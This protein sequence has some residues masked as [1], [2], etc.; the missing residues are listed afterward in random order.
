MKRKVVNIFTLLLGISMGGFFLKKVMNGKV[1]SWK[2]S[3]DKYY[4]LFLMMNQWVKLHQEG[5]KI[6][7]F[8]EKKGYHN[9]A[10]YGMSY[11]GETLMHELKNSRVKVQYGIDK[12]AGKLP[13][14]IKVVYPN[15]NLEEVDV[16]VVTPIAYYDEIKSELSEKIK[17][18]IVS[19]EDILYAIQ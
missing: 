19:L 7:I 3:S 2:D 18:P 12:N 15:E 14:D 1:N 8:F 4:S 13:L 9:I 6:S 17:C 10:I 5:K 16:I 11:A